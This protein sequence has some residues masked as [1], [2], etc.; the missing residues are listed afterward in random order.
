MS[1]L[2]H[3]ARYSYYFRPLAK[4][5]RSTQCPI[6][7]LP[8]PSPHLSRLYSATSADIILLY[9]NT[10]SQTKFFR[11]IFVMSGVQLVFWVYLSHFA[12]VELRQETLCG[13]ADQ[14]SEE[15]YSHGTT[16]AERYYTSLAP[17]LSILHIQFF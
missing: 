7:Q 13:E 15:H 17:S 10:Q 4:V 12:F 11:L 14:T 9:K 16:P 6:V 8:L 5:L 1:T 2:F 3:P